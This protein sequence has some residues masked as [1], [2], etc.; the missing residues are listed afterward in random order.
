MDNKQKI[1][2]V[3]E[4]VIVASLAF[5]FSTR[6]NSLEKRIQELESLN[7]LSSNMNDLNEHNTA[8]SVFGSETSKEQ[9]TTQ[10]LLSQSSTENKPSTSKNIPS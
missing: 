3:A 2:I 9:T 7:I 1:H 4:S 5:Y 6:I 8:S 10:P